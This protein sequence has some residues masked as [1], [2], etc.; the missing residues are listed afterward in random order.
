MV[1][2]IKNFKPYGV[3]RTGWAKERNIEWPVAGRS[4]HML[5]V[6]FGQKQSS[7]AN[8]QSKEDRRKYGTDLKA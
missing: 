6:S 4:S 5:Q 1:K 2:S 7:N 3:I 8:Y